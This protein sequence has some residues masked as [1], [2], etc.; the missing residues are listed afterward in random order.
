MET[1]AAETGRGA[2]D[3]ELT[4]TIRAPRSLDPKAFTWSKTMKVGDAAKQAAQ[5]FGYEGGSP[6]FQ[7]GEDILDRNKPFVA[8]KVQDGDVLDLVDA[9]GG[10]CTKW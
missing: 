6:T 4:V 9:G 1:Q 10:V 8:E 5:A 3:Q 2:G 7:K